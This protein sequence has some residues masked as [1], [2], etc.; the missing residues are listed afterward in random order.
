[1]N[2]KEGVPQGSAISPLLFCLATAKL[3][4]VVKEAAPNCQVDQ[5]A[6][7]LTIC[8]TDRTVKD[9]SSQLE[10]ALKAVE[11]WAEENERKIAEEKTA[12]AVVSV[13]PRECNGKADTS[14]KLAV[15]VV[16]P[17][18]EVEI[19]GVTIDSQLTFASHAQNVRKKLN[20]MMSVLTALSGKNWGP[21]SNDFRRVYN[22][23][24]KP[25]GCTLQRCGHTFSQIRTGKSLKH[26]T[27]GQLE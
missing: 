12:I 15:E 27:T 7:E 17:S 10:P 22:T 4:K 1:M 8:T 18:K 6:Y 26:A 19:L 9:A 2:L 23:Y 13:D 14:F 24:A 16:T 20:R 25:R 11:T 21:T 5:F 3:P